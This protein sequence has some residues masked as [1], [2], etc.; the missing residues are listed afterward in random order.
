M[1]P[2]GPEEHIRENAV[3]WLQF[4]IQCHC[5]PQACHQ[6]QRP[7]VQH[8]LCDLIL[9]I[10]TGRPQALQIG[11]TTSSTLIL[12]IGAPQDCMLSPLLYSLLMHDCVNTHSSNT[13]IKIAD[14]TTVV[15]LITGNNEMAYREEVRAAS[16]PAPPGSGTTSSLRPQDFLTLKFITVTSLH[17]HLIKATVGRIKKRVDLAWKCERV[18]LPGLSLRVRVRGYSSSYSGAVQLASKAPP[19]SV[20]LSNSFFLA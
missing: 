15:G 11:S 1:T 18:Q 16:G 4:S 2:S 8:C 12:N 10:L 14:D 9:N 7:W 20:A 13:I 3:H 19:Y 5:A 17:L 6:A